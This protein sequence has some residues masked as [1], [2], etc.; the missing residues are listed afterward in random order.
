MILPLLSLLQDQLARAKALNISAAIF[1]VRN[2]PESAQLVFTTPETSLGSGFQ[3]FLNRL[4]QFKRLDRIVIDECHVILN[5]SQTFRRKLGQLGDLVEKN[6]QFLLLTATLPPKYESNLFEILHL[7]LQ[8]ASIWRLSSNRPNIRYRVLQNQSMEDSLDFIRQKDIQYST[9]RLIVYAK[10]IDLAKQLANNL[11]WPVYYSHSS[12]KEQVLRKFLDL[13]QTNPRIIATSSL[14][15]GLDLPNIRA[16]IHVGRP[17][18]MYE[19]AQES[20]RAGRDGQN[21]EAILLLTQGFENPFQ[22]KRK[23]SKDDKHENDVIDRYSG[24]ECRRLVMSSYLDVVGNSCDS[25][26]VECDICSPNEPSKSYI[27]LYIILL[28][29]LGIKPVSSPESSIH[30]DENEEGFQSDETEESGN[31][32]HSILFLYF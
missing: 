7:Q 11:E 6:T 20:G 23:P 12:G 30:I 24:S 10:T 26:D 32:S 18:K 17:Y 31:Y 28:I 3:D 2:P 22:T 4:R 15:L 25:D 8:K 5:K 19:Y 27:F 1:N 16:I 21:S 14:G 13:T 9:D 29:F